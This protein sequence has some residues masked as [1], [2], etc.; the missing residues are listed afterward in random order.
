VE[1]RELLTRVEWSGGWAAKATATATAKSGYRL[2]W[3]GVEWAR[4]GYSGVEL[5]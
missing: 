3:T 5:G 1:T 4:V 2:E